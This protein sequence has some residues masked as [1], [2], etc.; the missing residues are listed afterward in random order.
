[1]AGSQYKTRRQ[2]M[3]ARRVIVADMYKQGASIRKIADAVMER[4]GLPKRPST[5]IIFQ[6]VQRLLREWREARLNDIDAAMQLELERIDDAIYELWQAWQKSKTDQTLTSKKQRGTA[7][8]KSAGIT[9]ASIERMEKQE[10]RYGDPR[11][12]AEIRQ[13]LAERRKLMGLYAPEKKEIS[14]EMSFAHMLMESGLISEDD[15]SGESNTGS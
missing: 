5:Q 6:D 1:M 13:Q 15:E 7:S 2:I 14:G 3:E 12:I 8:G 9:P 4:M 11:Y 10:I